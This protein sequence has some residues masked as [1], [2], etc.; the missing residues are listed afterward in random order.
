[1]KPP[2]QSDEAYKVSL[3]TP[4]ILAPSKYKCSISIK[5]ETKFGQHICVVGNIPELG[6]WKNIHQAKLQWSEGHVWKLKDAISV[7]NP[8]F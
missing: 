3:S 6:N 1:M 7:S 4:S 8:V 2:L 5:H